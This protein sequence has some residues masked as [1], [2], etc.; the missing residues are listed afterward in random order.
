MPIPVEIAG[1]FGRSRRLAAAGSAKVSLFLLTLI[2]KYKLSLPG[3]VGAGCERGPDCKSI[4][5][6]L[7]SYWKFAYFGKSSRVEAVKKALRREKQT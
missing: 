5:F 6:Y 3:L 1:N 2:K 7:K 4:T